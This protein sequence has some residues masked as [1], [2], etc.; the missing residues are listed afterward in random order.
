MS[1][2]VIEITID[3]NNR[4]LYFRPLQRA[5]RGLFLLSRVAEPTA[6]MFH[7]R[8]P[9]EI[10]GQ[11][12]GLDL[13]KSEGYLLEPIHQRPEIKAKLESE[14][15]FEPSRQVFPSV[16][17]QEW[18]FWFRAAV[19]AGK[20]KA[21]IGELPGTINHRPKPYGEVESPRDKMV[22]ALVAV[23]FSKLSKEEKAQVNELA[24]V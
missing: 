9:A 23:L 14:Y 8:I 19:Q 4:D 5:V 10:P 1:K 22:D 2:S 3:A 16:D 6:P 15:S 24:G 20:A 7:D 17:V 13:E 18:L 11:V 12:L 21:V